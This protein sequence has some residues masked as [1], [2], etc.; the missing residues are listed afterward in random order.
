M[1]TL[2]EEGK[3]GENRFLTTLTVTVAVAVLEF[4][5]KSVAVTTT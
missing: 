4:E 2:L 1:D 3:T 5:P